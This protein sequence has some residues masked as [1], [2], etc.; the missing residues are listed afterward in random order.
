[1]L[2]Q[3]SADAAARTIA[4]RGGW[5]QLKAVRT[6]RVYGGL[7]ENLLEQPGPRVLE[8]VRILERCIGGVGGP[9]SPVP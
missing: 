3:K 1:M 5:A 6:G 4:A 7:D 9:G 2:D 8:G